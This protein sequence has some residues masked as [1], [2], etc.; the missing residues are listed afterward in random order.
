MNVDIFENKACPFTVPDGYF[1]TLQE[2]VMNRIQ[3]E[4]KQGRII[5]MPLYRKMIAAAACVL[6]IFASATLYLTN[7]GKL[8]LIAETEMIIDDEFYRW[9]FASDAVSQ[10]AESLDIQMPENFMFYDNDLSKEEE[11]I[12]Q[13]LERDN[14]SVAA[15]L[16]SI[17]NEIY[18]YK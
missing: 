15:I 13:F 6:F 4:E 11:A 18:S 10:L 1:D 5:K 16:Y 9:F 3:A 12:I 8:S 7:T 17:D 14:I 2:R